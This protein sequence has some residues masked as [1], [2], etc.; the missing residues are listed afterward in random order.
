MPDDATE[1]HA[2]TNLNLNDHYVAPTAT[3]SPM[4]RRQIQEALAHHEAA[5]AV[6]A[7]SYGVRCTRV[8]VLRVEHAAGTGWTGRT[9]YGGG[10]ISAYGLAVV[11]AAGEHGEL[12]YL[13]LAGLL[14]PATRKAARADH[15]RDTSISAAASLGYTIT[16]DGPGPADPAAGATWAE[17][18]DYSGILV[19]SLW[20]AVAALA[21]AIIASPTLSLTGDQAADVIAAHADLDTPP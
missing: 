12:L 10:P 1:I 7:A 8:R 17:I 3:N 14:T 5:H 9:T 2:D 13:A 16:L 4:P 15:D 19:S 18:S 21:A 20:P 11:G 6:V